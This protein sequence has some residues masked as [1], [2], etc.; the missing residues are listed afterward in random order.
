VIG[1]VAVGMVASSASVKRVGHVSARFEDGVD[2]FFSV[3][4]RTDDLPDCRLAACNGVV[5]RM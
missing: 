2:R 5:S 3:D 4:R 1:S